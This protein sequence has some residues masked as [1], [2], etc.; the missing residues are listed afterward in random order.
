MDDKLMVIPLSDVRFLINDDFDFGYGFK[1]VKK[2]FEL[3]NH[4]NSFEPSNQYKKRIFPIN[5]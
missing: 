5:W 4:V 2:Q 3:K 1:V